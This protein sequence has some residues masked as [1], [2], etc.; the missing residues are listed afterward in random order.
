MQVLP[1]LRRWVAENY[2]GLGISIGEWD[3]GAEGHMS[4]G[5]ATAEALG[6][7]G[8]EGVHS[9]YR[10]GSPAERTP[11]FWAF[12]AFRN[13]DGKEGRFQDWS[14]PVKA[15]GT[16]VSLFAS[17][18]EA[19]RRI[20]A[21]LLNLAPVSPLSAEIALQGCGPVALADAYTYTGGV[22]G[23]SKL[24]VVASKDRVNTRVSPY[25]ISVLDL[26]IAAE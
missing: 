22:A 12:R 14:I 23:Y 13:F 8:T 26:A 18:D 2:P 19:R 24:G 9:A 7:F 6:R 15:D 10:W 11:A 20:V 3:F 16:L 17:R 4:G 5:L 21:V 1:L 25:S